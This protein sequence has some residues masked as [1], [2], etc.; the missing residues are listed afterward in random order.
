MRCKFFTQKTIE[1]TLNNKMIVF[2]GL[3]SFSLFVSTLVLSSQKRSL[4]N[5]VRN[6]SKD[7]VDNGGGGNAGESNN[8]GAEDVENSSDGQNAVGDNSGG[9]IGA[10]NDINKGNNAGEDSGTGNDEENKGDGNII[11]DD[12]QSNSGGGQNRGVGNSVGGKDEG[13]TMEETKAV[14]TTTEKATETEIITEATQ[15]EAM[16]K[17]KGDDGEGIDEVKK[18]ISR[19][20]HKRFVGV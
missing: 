20:I 4:Q 12:K 6:L 2:L 3:L 10:D 14:Q 16:M 13:T 19:T 7:A 1:W 9:R 11:E 8:G 5:E 17:V 15:H 18:R